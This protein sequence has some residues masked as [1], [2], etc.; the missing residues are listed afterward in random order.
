MGLHLELARFETRLLASESEKRAIELSEQKKTANLAKSKALTDQTLRN[1]AEMLALSEETNRGLVRQLAAV[2]E[3]VVD[4]ESGRH[5]SLPPRLALT[6]AEV[7][8]G[9]RGAEH[10][11]CCRIGV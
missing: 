2:R 1:A 4:L 7:A 9:R 3:E 8:A 11:A 10:A 5:P 6:A